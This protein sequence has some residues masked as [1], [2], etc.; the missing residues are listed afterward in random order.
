MGWCTDLFCNISFNR[1]TYNSKWEVENDIDELKKSIE[2]NENKL[3]NLAVMTEPNKFFNDPDCDMLQLINNEVGTCLELLQE[4]Y[5]DLYKLEMLLENWYKCHNEEGLAIYPP[6][7][8]KWDSAFLCGD[9]VSSTKY[10]DP[11]TID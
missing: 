1:K 3:H 10:P 2:Y 5:V 7:E 4:D 9:F 6:E 8:V 11:N